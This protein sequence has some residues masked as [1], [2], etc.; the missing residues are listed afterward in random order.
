ME[1]FSFSILRKAA[2]DFEFIFP[3]SKR[4]VAGICGIRDVEFRKIQIC[5]KPRQISLQG[6]IRATN[7]TMGIWPTFRVR[8]DSFFFKKIIPFFMPILKFS[9][10][11][12][13]IGFAQCESEISKFNPCRKFWP[14]WKISRHNLDFMKLAELD[15]KTAEFSLQKAQNASTAVYGAGGALK[16]GGN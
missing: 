8:I 16:A 13:S 10:E 14:F 7:A 6:T 4:A 3:M 12:F 11:C 2:M 9:R 1:H 15:R 5:E